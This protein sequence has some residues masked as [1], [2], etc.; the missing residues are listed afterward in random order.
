MISDIH[1]HQKLLDLPSA[2]L[3]LVA[4][5]MT[6]MGTYKEL[7]DFSKFLSSQK[8][9]F[10]AIIVIAGNH[11]ITMDTPFFNDIGKD[12]FPDNSF[13]SAKARAFLTENP[14]IIY[15]EDSGTEYKGIRIWGTPWIPPF[16]QWAFS[17]PNK[18]FAKKIFEKIPLDTD[19]LI[20]HSPPFGILD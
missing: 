7:E 15:L 14:D 13:E 6:N 9:K 12:Y 1:N 3:L 20:S 16:G 11:E 10:D 2:D 18:E 5:D 19:I 4:G 8:P 17:L